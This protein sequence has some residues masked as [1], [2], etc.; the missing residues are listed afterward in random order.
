MKNL[1]KAKQLGSVEPSTVYRLFN[2]QVPVVICSRSG[3]DVAAMPANS[4]SSSS[5]SPPMITVSLRRGT[6]TNKVLQRSSIFSINWLNFQPKNSRSIILKL[7]QPSKDSHDPDKLHFYKIPYTLIRKTPVLSQAC[8]YALCRVVK[9]VRTG[10]HDLFIAKVVKALALR[11]FTAD[12]YWRFEDY[13]P[14][15]YVGSIRDDPLLTI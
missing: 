8:A 1:P 7:S 4:C 9:Q 3:K 11:D 6:S 13:K 2:P 12:G 10:D 5:D 15:L 14:I